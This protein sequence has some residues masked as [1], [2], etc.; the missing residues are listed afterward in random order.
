MGLSLG[1]MLARV[2]QDRILPNMALQRLNIEGC[3]T[4]SHTPKINL[5][6]MNI[7]TGGNY[8]Y[9]INAANISSAT[10]A[11]FCPNSTTAILHYTSIEEWHRDKISIGS[12]HEGQIRKTPLSGL[13]N[14]QVFLSKN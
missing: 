11:R 12:S 10:G 1:F 2:I 3:T 9:I 13:H 5:L 7:I 6:I 4:S 8:I 14:V